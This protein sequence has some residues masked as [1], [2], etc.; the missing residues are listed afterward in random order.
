MSNTG[1][2]IG[3]DLGDK[4]HTA[5]ILNAAGDIIEEA[6]ISCLRK[7]VQ[8]FFARYPGAVVV[9]ES[10]THSCWVS[11]EATRAGLTPL[12]GNARRLRAIWDSAYKNDVRDA[13]L[14]AR[15][16]RADPKLLHP[17]QHRGKDAQVGLSILKARDV[18][19]KSRTLLINHVRGIVKSFGER[20]PASISA[21]AFTNKAKLPEELR[22]ALDPIMATISEL[23]VKIRAYDRLVEQVSLNYPETETLRQV[24]GV[25][26]LTALAYVLTLEDPQRF[27]SS[28]SVA[29]YLGLVPR[30][31][32]S[33]QTDKQLRITKA[34]NGYLRRLLVSSAH[35]IL[36]PFG[37][38]NDL[39]RF[40]MALMA[41]GGKNAKKRAVVAIARKLAVLL[42]ALWK[43]GQMYE[44]NRREKAVA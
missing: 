9:I 3:M 43:S 34:G 35:Y 38:D 8:K 14:L 22:P 1:I 40:G 32:Q 12:V 25:G 18:L 17:I 29:P 26:A 2:T 23:T 36:G 7:A 42:H 39:R 27:E 21:G 5:C 28:R 31:D 6:T 33:G 20:I 41:R 24:T 11:E 30:Q 19:V 10:G 13:E 15:I 16:G 4:N 44:P 37:P